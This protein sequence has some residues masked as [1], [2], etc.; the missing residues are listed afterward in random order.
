M[1]ILHSYIIFHLS[2]Q[3]V[4]IEALLICVIL[5]PL[6]DVESAFNVDL[7]DNNSNAVSMTTVRTITTI[8]SMTD[9]NAACS[10]HTIGALVALELIMLRM[11]V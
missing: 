4:H 9:N 8:E 5:V 11:L 7:N 1:H 3:N 2:V 10:L 6:T